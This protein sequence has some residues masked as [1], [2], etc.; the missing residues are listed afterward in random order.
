MGHPYYDVIDNSTD[1]ETKIR[2]VIQVCAFVLYNTV[3]GVQYCAEMS[4][5]FL[6]IF[7]IS[8]FCLGNC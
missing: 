3:G 5:H 4:L 1:F 6:T 7:I 2:R 8:T